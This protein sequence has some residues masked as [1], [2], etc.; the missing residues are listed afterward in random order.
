MR[1]VPLRRVCPASAGLSWLARFAESATVGVAVL[2]S[3]LRYVFVNPAVQAM[4]GMPREAT[5][6]RCVHELMPEMGRTVEPHLRAA[7]AGTPVTKKVTGVTPRN[8]DSAASWMVHYFPVE[9]DFGER[10][11]AVVSQEITDREAER[12]ASRLANRRLKSQNELLTTLANGMAHDLRTPLATAIVQLELARNACVSFKAVEQID[13]AISVLRH[14]AETVS[15]LLR[16]ASA[17]RVPSADIV[18]TRPIVERAWAAVG[19]SLEERGGGVLR[20]E[21]DL[22]S[23]MGDGALLA[24]LFQNLFDN[25]AKHGASPG[26]PVRVVVRGRTEGD[27]AIVEVCDSGA[28][29]EPGERERIFGVYAKGTGSP[30]MGLGLAIVDRIMRVH[31]GSVLVCD[32]EPR[33]TKFVLEFRGADVDMIGDELPA[34]SRAGLDERVPRGVRPAA[35]CD[36]RDDSRRSP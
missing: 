16:L 28:G 1:V 2:D 23:V 27:R 29:V 8:P 25:A 35:D 19:S 13:E 17:M 36:D 9:G 24:D 14:G 30:G 20:I 7:L 10:F 6:G 34:G 11:V 22:P 31:D 33:G 26:E 18:E 4:H 5:V 3:E 21:G 12:R 15:G 32:N